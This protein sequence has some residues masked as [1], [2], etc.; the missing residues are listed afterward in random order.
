MSRCC[1]WL[2][3]CDRAAVCGYLNAFEGGAQHSRV[4]GG[5]HQLCELLAAAAGAAGYGS[6]SRSRAI[7]SG[8]RR[9]HGA[10]P[11]ERRTRRRGCGR[12]APAAR[13]RHRFPARRCARRAPT[14]RTGRGC[15]VKVQLVYPEPLWRRHGLSG[16]SVSAGRSAD[17]HCRRL[18]IRRRCRRADRLRHRGRRRDR[19]AALTPDEQRP[20]PPSPRPA[21]SSPIFPTRSACM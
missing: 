12:A 6:A 5:A 13:R 7:A 19:F 1:T 11:T 17:V 2:S 20:R 4:D 3:T 16:W 14:A 9:R 18:P 10:T 15:A 8:R 21:A